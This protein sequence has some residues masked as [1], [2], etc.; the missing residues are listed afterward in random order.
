MHVKHVYLVSLTK[1]KSS[2]ME[3][4]VI[5]HGHSGVRKTWL[6]SV[7]FPFAFYFYFIGCRWSITSHI[8]ILFH[9]LLSRVLNLHGCGNH[10]ASN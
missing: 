8:S 3:Y 10:L 1:R 6:S 7:F 2:H 9:P 4:S 5:K